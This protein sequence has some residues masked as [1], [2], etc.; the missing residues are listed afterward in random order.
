MVFDI[1]FEPA[2]N[3][4]I[5]GPSKSGKTRLTYNLLLQKKLLFKEPPKH[6]LL[7]Y[8]QKQPIYDEMLSQGLITE[9][10]ENLPSF[11]DL[12]SKVM[13]YKASGGCFIIID[14]GLSEMSDDV[15]RIFTELTHHAKLTTILCVQSL[16]TSTK[17]MRTCTLNMHYL[18]LTKTPR[19]GSQIKTLAT[20]MSAFKVNFVIESF[21]RATRLP[22][23]Y[24]LL[25]YT[26]EIGDHLRLRSNIFDFEAPCIVF[27]EN[28]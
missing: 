21:R 17:S 6:A 23:S 22:Y 18:F 14:D 27:V 15:A 11:E 19:D 4:V 26:Q 20:Q 8:N 12:K 2:S 10:I 9:I 7:F 1:R 16:F 25:D 3:I 24:L 13:P 28:N 5:M